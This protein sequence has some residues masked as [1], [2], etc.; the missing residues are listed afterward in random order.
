MIITAME[1]RRKS[2]TA[3]YLDGQLAGEIDCETMLRMHLHIGDVLDDD[4]WTSLCA[5]SEIARAKSY[6]VWL[7]DRRSY[8]TGML[9]Q[10]MRESH[11]P[12]AIDT[13]LEWVQQIGLVDDADYARRYA[14]E[15]VRL[16]SFSGFRI[17]QELMHRGISRDLARQTVAELAGEANLPEPCAAIRSLLQGKFAGKYGD[18]KGRR[19]TVA[20]L[21]RMGYRWDNIRTVLDELSDSPGEI[22]EPWD[23]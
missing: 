20:A 9:R 22:C 14:S 1:P 3:V 4:A 15:L 6:A 23:N 8:T 7:L 19:R 17:E 16:R 13:T 5:E 21:Q 2:L 12:A 10:K 11:S 18:E